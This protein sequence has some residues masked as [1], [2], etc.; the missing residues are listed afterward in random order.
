MADEHA[1][2]GTFASHDDAEAA[3]LALEKAGFDM[4][5]I[6]IIGKDYR[7]T[8]QVRG[9]LTW[10]DT[11]KEGAV[12]AG[13]WGGFF[14]GLFGILVGAGVLFIPGVGQVVIAGPI[15][16]VLAGW[17]EGLLLGAAGGAAAGG[18][19][20]ALVGLGIPEGKA[21]KYDSDI[22]AGKFLVLVTGGEE[23]RARAEQAL[24]AAGLATAEVTA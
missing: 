3:V 7:T 17:L 16:G 19:V 18:L 14:G 5:K 12:S 4:H 22:Q 10:R 13:Y 11:A 2:V 6:S 20:G 15:A 23:D 8:Q 21:I 9:F 1:V 24:A